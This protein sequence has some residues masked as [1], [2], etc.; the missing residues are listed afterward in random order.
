MLHA[1]ICQNRYTHGTVQQSCCIPWTYIPLSMYVLKPCVMASIS[2]LCNVYYIIYCI[3]VCTSMTTPASSEVRTPHRWG[4]MYSSSHAWSCTV[5][6][7]ST[8]T[9]RKSTTETEFVLTLICSGGESAVVHAVCSV[10]RVAA[11]AVAVWRV[12]W[13]PAVVYVPGQLGDGGGLPGGDIVV[14]GWVV[15]CGVGF[16]L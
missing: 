13:V 6:R 4:S 8:W 7:K 12:R 11:A 15:G 16:G 10:V 2:F 9:W 5:M 14:G 3:H 1:I